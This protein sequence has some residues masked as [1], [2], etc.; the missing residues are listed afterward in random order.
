MRTAL[1]GLRKRNLAQTSSPITTM[2]P[3][4]RAS[5]VNPSNVM[6]VPDLVPC[7]RLPIDDVQTGDERLFPPVFRILWPRCH[8]KYRSPRAP[9][10]PWTRPWRSPFTATDDCPG[11]V[12]L[13]VP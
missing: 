11:T 13:G 2:V 5:R 8:S 9:C 10:G 4:I 12:T 3:L 6:H 7:E 1:I